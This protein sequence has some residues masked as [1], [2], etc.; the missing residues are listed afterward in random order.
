MQRLILLIWVLT[1]TSCYLDPIKNPNDWA[2][3]GAPHQNLAVQVA[4]P[5]DLVAGK[6][7][8]NANGVAAA[9]GV[10]K[11]LGGAAGTGIG[12][13]TPP[14]NATPSLNIASGS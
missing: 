13:L 7:N 1:L 14:A 10:D 8:P 5:T 3:T 6:G 12:L 9:S 2:L 4:N 11:A